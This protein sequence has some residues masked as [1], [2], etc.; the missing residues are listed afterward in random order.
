MAERIACI[1]CSKAP[2][3]FRQIA[4]EPGYPLLDRSNANARILS[5]W[6]GRLAAEPERR[7]ETISWFIRSEQGARLDGVEVSPI[8][9]KDLTSLLKKELQ[10][11]ESRLNA[12]EP[13]TRAEQAVHRTIK[14]NLAHLTKNPGQPEHD[15]YFLKYRDEQGKWRLLWMWGFERTDPSKKD[16]TAIC[17]KNDCRSL[18]LNDSGVGGKCPHCKTALPIPP[19]PWKR[20]A[21][22]AMFFFLLAGAG[23]GGWWYMQPRATLTGV[24]LWK[25]NNQP[26]PGVEVRIPTLEVTTTTDES[27]QFLFDRLPEG[28]AEIE[29]SAS[30]FQPEKQKE[31]LTVGE[32]TQLKIL[33][34]GNATLTGLVINDKGEMGGKKVPLDDVEIQVVG[35]NLKGRSDDEGTFTIQDLPS[36]THQIH[37]VAAGFP[38]KEV[39][40]ELS[41]EKTSEVTVPLV[42]QGIVSGKVL[43]ANNEQPI[44]GATVELVGSGQSAESDGDGVFVI[45]EVPTG[46]GELAVSAQGFA[47]N[48]ADLIVEEKERSQRILLYGAGILSG[49]VL[50]DG[51]N[52]PIEGAKV[53]I[54]G[55]RLSTTTDSDGRFSLPSIPAGNVRVLISATGYRT[56]KIDKEVSS[57]RTTQLKARLEGGA[58]LA[59]K[60]IDGTT[61]KPVANAEVLASV[62]NSPL[63]TDEAGL[64]KA[65]GVKAGSAKITA[66]ASGFKSKVVTITLKP[67]EDSV[68]EIKLLGD[69]KLRGTLIDQVTRQPIAN[70]ELKIADTILTTKTNAD[71]AFL[72]DGPRSGPAKIEINAKGYPS[73]SFPE[74]LSSGQITQASWELAGA[75]VLTG[76]VKDLAKDA[77][78][79]GA[80]ATIAGTKISVKSDKDGKFK[81]EKLPALPVM[82]KITAAGYNPQTVEQDITPNKPATIEVVL[83][84]DAILVGKVYDTIS[85]RPIPN[86]KIG[87]AGNSLA[88]RSNE[89]G[90]FRLENVF[91]GK[92]DVIASAEGYPE[93]QKAVTVESMKESAV[94]LPLTGS[95]IALGKVI[96]PEGDPIEGAV[97]KWPG[98][99]HETKTGPDGKFELAKLPGNEVPLEVSA[100]HYKAQTIQAKLKTDEKVTLPDAK[101][102]SGLNVTGEVISALNAKGLPDIKVAIDGSDVTATSNANGQ[103]VLESVPTKPFTVQIKGDGFYSDTIEVDPIEGDRTIKPV[104]APV[105][106]PG[107]I[108]M[109]VLWGNRIPDLDLHVFV[110]TD[111][112]EKIHI[113][114]KN[115]KTKVGTLDVDNR[116]GYGPETITLKDPVPGKYQIWVHAYQDPKTE[117]TLEIGQSNA[118]VRIYQAGSKKGQHILVDKTAALPAWNVG[119][120]E[121]APDRSVNVNKYGRLNYKKELP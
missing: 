116:N 36:G 25:G 73:Q 89:K 93:I 105:L 118:D 78:V 109:V 39:A 101:L 48:R 61:N 66:N 58:V 34:T 102:T 79:P 42:G 24:V 23:F 37:V 94:E 44:S 120:I 45:K 62:V 115:R 5:K 63:I 86:A 104:L 111:K 31:A 82:L 29:I 18:F 59:G 22:A 74:K 112:G 15:S 83:G 113:W 119:L 71:G 110:T 55:K 92:N 106:K 76:T 108:R 2:K 114:H 46:P 56:A 35:T 16:P 3:N 117:G 26:V 90:E 32:E 103:F 43:Q 53:A 19:N 6:V 81:L 121:V 77:P 67:G 30:G 96:S 72:F 47:T 14:E 107:E 65:E 85:N 98:T 33:L 9:P 88:T 91:G 51:D 27:G 95:A 68:V 28:E 99:D 54:D 7:G 20:L 10:E 17:I 52:E 11:L 80:I 38:E 13:R 57:G 84:G 64:F 70:A 21:I 60:V 4:L 50:S 49:T 41:P 8:H 100:T 40:V 97:V 1:D 87:I 12:V 75:S 69:A